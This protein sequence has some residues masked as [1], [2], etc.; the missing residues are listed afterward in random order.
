LAIGIP[1]VRTP[2]LAADELEL[3]RFD[4]FAPRHERRFDVTAMGA[5]PLLLQAPFE[6]P[7]SQS[8]LR[9]MRVSW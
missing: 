2:P 6:T 7:N 5:E 9:G 3:A 1:V 4:D 8:L